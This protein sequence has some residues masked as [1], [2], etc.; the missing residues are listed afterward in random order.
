MEN[1]TIKKDERVERMKRNWCYICCNKAIPV[2]EKDN[3][4]K[5]ID[6]I[7]YIDPYLIGRKGFNWPNKIV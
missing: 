3:H 4:E 6:H 7:N 5:S 1:Q 2:I